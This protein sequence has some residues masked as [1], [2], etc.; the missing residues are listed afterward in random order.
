MEILANLKKTDIVSDRELI[1]FQ[2]RKRF[3]ASECEC[4]CVCDCFCSFMPNKKHYGS[5]MVFECQGD[6]ACT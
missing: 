5:D 1:G 6:C 3:Y 4:D 2:N